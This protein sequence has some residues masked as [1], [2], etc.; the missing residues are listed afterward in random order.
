MSSAAREHSL[1]S[2]WKGRT[3][4]ED[5][6]EDGAEAGAEAGTGPGLG[7]QDGAGAWSRFRQ[8]PLPQHEVHELQPL[9]PEEALSVGWQ[10]QAGAEGIK[11]VLHHLLFLCCAGVVA[12]KHLSTATHTRSP[13]MSQSH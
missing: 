6:A 10:H 7:Q 12:L 1:H 9:P 13:S 2:T 4:A 5:G 11:Q 8:P 3:G